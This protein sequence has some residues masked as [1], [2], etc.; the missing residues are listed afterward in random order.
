MRLRPLLLLVLVLALTGLAAG[1][2]GGGG[3]GASAGPAPSARPEDFPSVTGKATLG[4]LIRGVR[5]GPQ[6]APG[7]SLL[8]PG[9]HNRFGFALIDQAGKQMNGAQVAIYTASAQQ[10][11]LR[12][13]FPARSES[14]EVS[15]AYRSKTA[16]LDPDSAKAVYVADVPIAKAGR[17]VMIALARLDGRLVASSAIAFQVSGGQGGPPRVGEPA[18]KVDTPT[19]RDVRDISEIDTRIPPGTMH[20]ANL[21]DVLGRKPVVLTF[22]TPALCKSRVCGPIVDEL[23]EL[24]AQSAGRAEFIHMEVYNQNKVEKGYRPQFRAWHLPSEPWTFMI[25]RSGR[26]AAE[27]EGPVSLDELRQGLDR[28]VAG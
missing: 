5:Q 25:A 23:E 19:R 7:V 21:A 15:P 12:G 27:F 22:A 2:G 28:A 6:L 14:L 11:N 18:I 3:D 26:I 4:D 20:D 13:P 24:K 8:Y 16:S 1:C 9:A 17:H 10:T